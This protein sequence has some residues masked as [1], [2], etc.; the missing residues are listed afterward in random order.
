M[1]G[2]PKFA[3]VGTGPAGLGVL[4]ALLDAGHAGR[5]TLFDIDR[6]IHVPQVVEEPKPDAI[7]SFYDGVYRDIWRSGTRT[8]PPPKTH[9]AAAL[10]KVA[11]DGRAKIIRSDA[12]G[13]LSNFWGGTALPFT[14]SE[15]AGWP[16]RRADLDAHYQRMADVC[17]ISGRPDA[18][19]RY[20]GADFVNRP[21]MHVT[22]VF[23]RMERAVNEADAHAGFE[24]VAGVN[25]CMLE[26]RPGE[27]RSCVRCGECHA[28]CFRDSVFSTRRAIAAMIADGRV[29]LAR[30]KVRA[31]HTPAR[32]LSIEGAPTVGPFDRI[33][34]AAG[35]PNTTEIALRSLGARDTVEMAE[36]AVYIFPVVYFGKTDRSAGR[37]PYVSLCNLIIALLPTSSDLPFAQA[38]L[39]TNFD[40]LWRYNIPPAL[41]PLARGPIARSRDRL[42]WARLYVHGKLSQSYTIAMDGDTARVT[43][44]RGPDKRAV[45][46]LMPVLRHA[47]NRH[48]FYVPPFDPVYQN[49]S[50]HYAATL[51]PGNGRSVHVSPAGEIAPGVFV[52]DSTSFPDLP[53]VSLTFTVM[54]HGHR[55]AAQSL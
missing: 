3:V 23:D 26:T 43:P 52:C 55:V 49:V 11:L 4:T 8:F 45:A 47:L 48:R 41:W 12:L 16:V 38:Q 24:T 1:S 32:V 37:E 40:Y 35:C 34:L 42:F 20:F 25:R 15:L 18:L 50:F 36:N 9:F 6:P 2:P 13:G 30:G 44:A 46:S 21:P 7:A 17:G 39:Y 22:R 51:P 27:S 29:A 28:G 19:N 31:F 10:P 33:Y 5:I 53:A 14:D 54:A